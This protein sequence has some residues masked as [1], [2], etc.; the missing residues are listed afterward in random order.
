MDNGYVSPEKGQSHVHSIISHLKITC[1]IANTGDVYVNHQK[2]PRKEQPL[3]NENG[4]WEAVIDYKTGII[5]NWSKGVRAHIR[6]TLSSQNEDYC[7]LY[8]Y[9]MQ[10]NLIC[11]SYCRVPQGLRLGCNNDEN[12]IF[13]DVNAEGEIDGWEGLYPTQLFGGD[14]FQMIGLLVIIIND[15]KLA[16][17]NPH[18]SKDKNNNWHLE[19]VDPTNGDVLTFSP[20]WGMYYQ[21]DYAINGI[22]NGYDIVG[23][24]HDLRSFLLKRIN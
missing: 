6:Y 18:I 19:C 3:F 13:I 14:T 22:G 17:L 23:N 7:K 9:G 5:R 16:S 24:I 2:L 1:R 4:E 8:V 21:Y 15:P 20:S 11:T 10:D 12:A